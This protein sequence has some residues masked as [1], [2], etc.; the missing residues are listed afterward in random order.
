ME[1][2]IDRGDSS[3]NEIAP[4]LPFLNPFV[5]PDTSTIPP[6]RPCLPHGRHA[7]RRARG[8]HRDPDFSGPFSCLT[9]VY[10]HETLAAAVKGSGVVGVMTSGLLAQA[11]FASVQ[12]CR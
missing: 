1:N 2:T 7:E 11:A 3:R 5:R 12:A 4:C 8:L 10:R 6:S 9:E